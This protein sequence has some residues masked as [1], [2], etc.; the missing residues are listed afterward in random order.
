LAKIAILP[1][2]KPLRSQIVKRGKVKQVLN[3]HII[4]NLA[5][6]YDL[7]II[8]STASD[9]FYQYIYEHLPI[10]Q[11][12]KFRLYGRS[13]FTGIEIPAD[14]EVGADQRS[15]GWMQILAENHIN[16]EPIRKT[17]G[18]DL[19]PRMENFD[20]RHIEG[21]VM[22]DRVKVLSENDFK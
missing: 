1:T 10:H 12:P 9:E 16:F 15:L 13:F 14:A 20:W 8:G 7:V 5:A 4:G 21:F 22:D 17:M 6:R 19:M 11:R 3:G 2:S 18:T